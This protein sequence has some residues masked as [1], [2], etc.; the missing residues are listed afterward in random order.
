MSKHE[1]KLPRCSECGGPVKLT[2]RIGRTREYRRGVALPIPDDFEIPTC[3]RCGE[4]F[5][6]PE[7]SEPLDALLEQVFLNPY[8]GNPRTNLGDLLD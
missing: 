7:V 3:T 1:M 8:S 6:I 4:E 2:A 5:M